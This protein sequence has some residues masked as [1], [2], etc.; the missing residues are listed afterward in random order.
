MGTVR[1]YI[2]GELGVR[3]VGNKEKHGKT[4]GCRVDVVVSAVVSSGNA[5]CMTVVSEPTRRKGRVLKRFTEIRSWRFRIRVI[6]R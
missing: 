1:I 6:A 4:P 3:G 2:C 5:I